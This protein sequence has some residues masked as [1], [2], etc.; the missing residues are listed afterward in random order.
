M[1]ICIINEGHR[2][3]SNSCFPPFSKNPHGGSNVDNTVNKRYFSFIVACATTIIWRGNLHEAPKGALF[4]HFGIILLWIVMP[5]LSQ[6]GNTQINGIYT[7]L[8]FSLRPA[9][10][11]EKFA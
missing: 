4:F 3:F 11:E 6:T 10:I 2:N 1:Q 7:V 9:I 5:Y 8:V